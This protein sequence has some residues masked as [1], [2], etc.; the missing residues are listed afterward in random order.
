MKSPWWCKI[1]PR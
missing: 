1:Y